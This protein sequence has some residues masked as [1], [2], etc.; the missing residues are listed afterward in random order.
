[1]NDSLTGLLEKAK[2][3]KELRDKIYATRND[4]NPVNALCV[5]STS[6]VE[7]KTEIAT[8]VFC[9]PYKATNYFSLGNDN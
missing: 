5:L 8:F 4:R 2:N 1:M 9:S 6:V 3:D 7:I